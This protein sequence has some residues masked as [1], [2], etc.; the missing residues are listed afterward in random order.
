M[1]GRVPFSDELKCTRQ[2]DSRRVLIS[3]E[4]GAHIHPS[5]ITKIDRFRDKGILVSD[6]IMSGSRTP[7]YVFDASTVNSQS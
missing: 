7:L 6:D 2:S 3:R 5:Y 4:S 1:M